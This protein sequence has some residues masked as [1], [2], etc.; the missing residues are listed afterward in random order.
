MRELKKSLQDYLHELNEVTMPA[1]LAAGFRVNPI[2]ARESLALMTYNCCKNSPDIASVIDTYAMDNT[3]FAVPV[4]VFNPDPTESLPV[5]IYI[6]GGGH[7]AGSVSVYNHIYRR[8]A[9][10]ANV[11]VVAPEYRLAPENPYPAGEIDI[12]STLHSVYAMLDDLGYSYKR[13]LYVGGDSGGGALTACLMRDIQHSN[14]DIKGQILIYPSLDYTMSFPSYGSDVNGEGYLL[15]TEQVK[16]YFDNYFLNRENR[17][18]ASPVFGEI[19]SDMP[20]TLLFTAEFC[21]LKDE[22]YEYAKRLEDVGVEV[23]HVHFDNMIHAYLNLELLCKEE[24]DVTYKE[25][26]NFINK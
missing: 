12:K 23:K 20:K 8:I 2:N 10:E 5:L 16:W 22:G 24:V 26:S 18:K 11:I 4:R 9:K 6:H 1:L 19:S 17:R 15:T 21:P 7:M 13:E 3:G 14:F 25:I